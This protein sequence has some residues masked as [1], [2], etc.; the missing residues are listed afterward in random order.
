MPDFVCEQDTK[1]FSNKKKKEKQKTK[2]KTQTGLH[3]AID[4]WNYILLLSFWN[5]FK[6]TLCAQH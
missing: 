5:N 3:G 6:V 1:A 2:N 4:G